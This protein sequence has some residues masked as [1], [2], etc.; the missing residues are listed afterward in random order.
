[1]KKV[2]KKYD[3]LVRDF[4]LRFSEKIDKMNFKNVLSIPNLKK[5]LLP[6]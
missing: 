1:M 6:K 3:T 5:V 2:F 4:F